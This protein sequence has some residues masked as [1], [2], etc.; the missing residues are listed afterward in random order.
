MDYLEKEKKSLN[1]Q[2][3][4][5]KIILEYVYIVLIIIFFYF[6]SPI[7]FEYI[8]GDNKG[9]DGIGQVLG[10][11]L[12]LINIAKYIFIFIYGVINPIRTYILNKDEI[13]KI[14]SKVNKSIYTFII[15]FPIILSIWI[16]LEMPISN[17]LYVSKY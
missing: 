13:K 10:I 14:S 3:I 6:L 7:L 11:S 12:L 16:V 9:I 8:V 17:Y 4:K 2:S 15:F 5:K 1:N